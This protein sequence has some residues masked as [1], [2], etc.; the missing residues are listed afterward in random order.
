MNPTWH[1]AGAQGTRHVNADAVA[2]RGGRVFALADGI[3]DNAVAAGAAKLA[4]TTAVMAASPREG[5]LAAQQALRALPS[6]DCVLVVAHVTDLGYR[7]A[8]VGDARAYTWDGTVVRQLT[9]DHTI[10]QYFADRGVEVAAHLANVVT[11]SVRTATDIGE[12]D[13]YHRGGLLLTSD[14]V[15]KGLSDTS[16]ASLVRRSPDPAA[17][18]VSSAPGNDNATAL[19]VERGA[20]LPIFVAA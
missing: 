16:I 3:G 7:V 13:T 14:G 1:L 5:V 15:H 17:A 20:E 4:A 6:G 8:W 11:S 10:A 2:S 12:V 9:H 18:L 19:M